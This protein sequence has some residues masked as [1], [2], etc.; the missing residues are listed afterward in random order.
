MDGKG[1]MGVVEFFP[2]YGQANAFTSKC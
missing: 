2:F 1:Q